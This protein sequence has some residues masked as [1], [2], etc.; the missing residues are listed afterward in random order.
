MSNKAHITPIGDEGI[1][2]LDTGSWRIFR[3][4]MNKE[5]CIECGICFTFCPVNS[6]Y[7]D[8]QNKYHISMDYCKGCGICHQ[9]CPKKAIDMIQE[10]GKNNG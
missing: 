3:P 4:V 10:G 1:Y 9:E 7:V 2:T 8:S 6:I 5:K